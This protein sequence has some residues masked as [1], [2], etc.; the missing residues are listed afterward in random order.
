MYILLVLFTLV[1]C[2]RGYENQRTIHADVDPDLRDF[3]YQFLQY[4]DRLGVSIDKNLKTLRYVDSI[5]GNPATTGPIIE[6]ECYSQ[7]INGQDVRSIDI[8]RSPYGNNTPWER[9]LLR[10][11]VFHEMGHCV[12]GLKHTEEGSNQIMDP[13]LTMSAEYMQNNWDDMVRYEF[14]SKGK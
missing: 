5:R 4:S 9:T 1:G 2:G 8:R 12:I 11:I 3:Y 13:V 14:A 7:Y 6:G 10:T